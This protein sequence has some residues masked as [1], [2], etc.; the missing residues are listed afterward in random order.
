VAPPGTTARN[1]GRPVCEVTEAKA[2]I[3]GVR[4]GV[5]CKKL[6]QAFSHA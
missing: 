4:K 2:N 1:A 5:K 6:K 3:E